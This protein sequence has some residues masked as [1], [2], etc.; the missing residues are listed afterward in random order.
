MTAIGIERFETAYCTQYTLSIDVSQ[1]LPHAKFPIQG[2]CT[3]VWT[4]FVEIISSNHLSF[5]LNFT[6]LERPAIITMLKYNIIFPSLSTSLPALISINP[7]YSLQSY[8]AYICVL[9]HG[10]APSGEWEA[11]GESGLYLSCSLWNLL[12]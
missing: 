3:S 7:C 9:V 1:I 2:L 12:K 11:T 8:S 10:L 5:C 6:S 4:Y